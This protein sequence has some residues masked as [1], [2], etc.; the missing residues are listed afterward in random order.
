MINCQGSLRPP[1]S[2]GLKL[3]LIYLFLL[4]SLLPLQGLEGWEITLIVIA[5]FLVLALIAILLLMYAYGRLVCGKEKK[6][7]KRKPQQR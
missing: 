7:K 6:K 5:V 1:G 4:P 2:L 3:T